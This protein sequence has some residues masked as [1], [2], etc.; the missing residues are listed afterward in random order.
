MSSV[1]V[2]ASG[3][4]AVTRDREGKDADVEWAV[5]GMLPALCFGGSS[6]PS[7]MGG[8]GLASTQ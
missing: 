5:Q 3:V 4:R 6:E 1:D 2:R 8:V 7:R